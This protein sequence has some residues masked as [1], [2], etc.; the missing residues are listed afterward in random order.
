MMRGW[1]VKHGKKGR[2]DESATGIDMD[3]AELSHVTCTE[4]MVWVPFK[5]LKGVKMKTNFSNIF[6]IKFSPF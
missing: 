3:R 1:M 4:A 5:G 6:E 2:E